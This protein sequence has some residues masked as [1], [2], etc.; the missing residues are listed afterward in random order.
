[1]YFTIAVIALLGFLYLFNR[2]KHAFWTNRGF[3]QLEPK[4]F[5]GDI[6]PLITMKTS[7]GEFFQSIYV[8]HKRHKAL[9]IYM[10]YSPVVVVNDPI[11]LQHVMV[12]DFTSFHD[13]PVPFD[14]KHDTLQNHLFH[15]PGKKW[16]DLRV[17]LSP[18]FTSGKL[19]GMFSVINDSGKVLEEYLVKHV[20]KGVNT[21]EFRELFA[22]LNT[23]IISSVAFGIENDC[24][25]EPDHIFRRMGAK[26]FEVNWRA[27]MRNILALFAPKLIPLFKFK[28][29]DPQLEEFVYSVV[30]QTVDYREKNNVVRND[31]M[32]LLIQLKDKGY[33]SVD[34]GEDDDDKVDHDMNKL[35]FDDLAANVFV[36]FQ[37]G[38]S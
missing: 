1:M 24:I 32:Q 10:S 8:R 27:I 14:L 38:E 4:F 16:R 35:S 29:T 25:N 6:G 11:L 15:I 23:S 3:T 19:K 12:R 18:V 26:V 30:K 33:V 2:H 9:G 17:K 37:A 22:R 34:K 7:I 13:R 20:E 36:F 5:I 31:F 28:I 21:F